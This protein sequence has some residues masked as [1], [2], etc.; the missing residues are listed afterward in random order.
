M[1]R[2][3]SIAA[4]LSP[5]SGPRRYPTDWPR[6]GPP[7]VRQ[8]AAQATQPV[9]L[10][11]TRDAGH[12]FRRPFRPP[13]NVQT[14][15]VKIA[16]HGVIELE[17]TDFC[18]KPVVAE[19]QLSLCV[20]FSLKVALPSRSCW[21]ADSE[22]N[23]SKTPSLGRFPCEIV[24]FSYHA[25]GISHSISTLSLTFLSRLSYSALVPITYS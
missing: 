17:N 4:S 18:P 21:K 11:R 20:S 10:L 7:N 25:L 12:L 13:G 6:P 14:V 8:A 5:N 23:A 3:R 22:N 2:N 15:F 19:P 9:L 16:G 24:F 1:S